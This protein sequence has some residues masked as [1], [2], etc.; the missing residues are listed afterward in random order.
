MAIMVPKTGPLLRSSAGPMSNDISMMNAA[1]QI[2]KNVP[3]A[4]PPL[5]WALWA[6]ALTIVIQYQIPANTVTTDAQR[7]HHSALGIR[8]T[9]TLDRVLASISFIKGM[10]RSE[11]RR[12]GKE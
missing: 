6:S 10:F 11:E 4:R 3:M 5:V 9:T 7:N 2:M 12:V 1:V 8:L